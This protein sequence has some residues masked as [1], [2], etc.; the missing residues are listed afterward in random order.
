MN[1]STVDISKLQFQR[2]PSPKYGG[3]GKG[4]AE[5]EADMKREDE[6]GKDC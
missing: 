3:L 4:H 5:I 1:I 6:G 2:N